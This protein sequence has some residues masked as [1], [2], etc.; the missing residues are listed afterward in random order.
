MNTRAEIK[1][2]FDDYN[3]TGFGGWSWE[4]SGPT[5]GK[6]QGKFAKLINGKTSKPL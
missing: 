2:A 3:N 4:N 1:E 5:H 6:Y